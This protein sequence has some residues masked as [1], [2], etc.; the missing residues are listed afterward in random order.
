MWN[1]FKIVFYNTFIIHK[2]NCFTHRPWNNFS[3]FFL[4]IIF[5]GHEFNFFFTA[6]FYIRPDQPFQSLEIEFLCC[7][8]GK[9]KPSNF[10][11]IF[12]LFFSWYVHFIRI[13]FW[14][15]P[16]NFGNIC[17][18]RQSFLPSTNRFQQHTRR[19]CPNLS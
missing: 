16:D 12:V 1:S 6:V 18:V 3:A 9:C 11:C 8:F 7:C 19:A 10:D 15:W 13:L 2:F 4:S 17:R 14:A 5:P